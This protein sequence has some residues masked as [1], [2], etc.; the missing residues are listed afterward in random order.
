MSLAEVYDV[1]QSA[2]IEGRL[3]NVL[4]R[5]KELAG[6]HAALK[7]HRSGLIA[8]FSKDLCASEAGTSEEIELS[9]DAVKRLYEQL[10]FPSA[11]ARERS[12][13][14][15]QEAPLNPVALG[16][17][18]IQAALPCPLSSTIIPLA[19]AVAAGSCCLVLLC[20]ASPSISQVLYNIIQIG[21]DQEAIG[22]AD[23]PIRLEWLSKLR[24]E[25]A[26]LQDP[27]SSHDFATA[28]RQTNSAIRIH[29]PATGLP[30]VFV[31]RSTP[32]LEKVATW[33]E[34]S[35][36]NAPR[37]HP[38]RM[39][40]LCFVDEFVIEQLMSLMQRRLDTT[41]NV[42]APMPNQST[43]TELVD[44]LVSS[45]P[46][47]KK[48]E[49]LVA[50]N[51]LSSL[52]VLQSTDSINSETVGQVANL[53]T[54]LYQG[55]LLIPTSSL[56]Y[57]IDLWNKVNGGTPA[58]ATYVFGE[59]KETWYLS[60]F[61]NSEHCFVNHIPPRSFVMIAPSS[62]HDTFALPF[63]PDEF[64]RNRAILQEPNQNHV[65]SRNGWLNPKKIA[66]PTGG[67]LSY[68]EQGLIV[69][70]SVTAIAASGF[71]FAVFKGV[72]RIYY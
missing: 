49:P 50:A 22:I 39:P 7:N 55:I 26:V 3:E 60:Q 30:A 11:L 32:K 13:Q 67:R 46:S 56:D 42:Q 9:L 23:F 58:S 8:A 24:F 69:G 17:V 1:V 4:Q 25:L 19:A 52:I 54:K 61:L 40:R 37:Q 33:L 45:F 16:P 10:D 72:K 62:T 34:Q 31:D 28:L 44:L 43:A 64:S 15:G 14:A 5:Q 51:K 41:E 68:F 38:G 20:T 36:L 6:L 2:W 27:A 65:V 35:I 47:L 63:R 12:V 21:M 66:Q 29:T 71:V 48:K 18:L 57:G 70:L 59:G 53:V